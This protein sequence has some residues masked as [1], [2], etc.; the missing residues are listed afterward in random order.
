MINYGYIYKTTNLI[1]NKVYIGRCQGAFT[2]KYLGSGFHLCRAV[3]KYG[4]HNFCVEIITY[5]NTNTELDEQEKK[6]IK[7][8]RKLLGKEN[9]YNITDGGEG[10]NTF[11]GKH[12]SKETILKISIANKGK[13]RTEEQ[14]RHI[15]VAQKA[16][17]RHPHS[18]ET[19]RKIGIGNKGKKYSNETRMK[20][21]IARTGTKQSTESNKKRSIALTGRI[22]SEEHK[23]KIALSRIGKKHRLE[24]IKK[25]SLAKIGKIGYSKGKTFEGMF[26]IDRAKDI[27][28]RRVKAWKETMNK[29]QKR[30]TTYENQNIL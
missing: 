9:I 2:Q 10:G 17:V 20:I 21:S 16:K 15:S 1:N 27:L 18:E 30:G 5:T 24:S 14:K 13:K 28:N 22:F 11:G 7:E 29:K 6:F 12:H 23:R 25:M 8:Y 3:N 19:K 26:G 4:K